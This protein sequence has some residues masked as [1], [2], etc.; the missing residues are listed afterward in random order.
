MTQ[1]IVTTLEEAAQAVEGFE[2]QHSDLVARLARI[3]EDLQQPPTD[4]VEVE[5]ARYR[6]LA[7]EKEGVVRAIAGTEVAI[8]KAKQRLDDFKNE[9]RDREYRRLSAQLG[10]LVDSVIVELD[11]VCKKA[12]ELEE[13]C[14][15]IGQAGPRAKDAERSGMPL[16]DKPP[17]GVLARQAMVA[18]QVRV[19]GAA[20]ES[21]FIK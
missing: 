2:K 8:A 15:K 12:I 21:G 5:I 20:R 13:L 1:A 3:D 14:H 7:M 6:D 4:N 11:S 17:L 18:A 16:P 9:A 10:P 19:Q